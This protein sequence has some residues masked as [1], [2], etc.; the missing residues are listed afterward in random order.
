MRTQNPTSVR[1]DF[2]SSLDDIESTFKAAQ[3]SGMND[4]SKR[5]IA[6]YLFVAAA[7]LFE[8]FLSDLV[9]A[10][11]NRDSQRFREFLLGGL[12]IDASE[13][14]ARRAIPHVEAS[15]PHLS[16]DKIR[17][18]LDPTGYNVTFPSTDKMKESAGRWLASADKARFVGATPAQCAVI[19]FV[20][21]VRNYLAHRS[22]AARN[23]LDEV[24][25]ARDLP[26]A[27]RRGI[28]AATDVGAYLLV[29]KDGECRFA[30]AIKALRALASRFCP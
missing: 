20:K 1:D 27:L 28:Y 19:D 14:Y 30:H 8:G 5:L 29:M 18:I 9:V 6:E 23:R 7:T 11:I 10:Y 21:A 13:D 15:I 3:G 26:K 22:D 25:F 4:A 24:I 17:E 16:V 12:S 2:S